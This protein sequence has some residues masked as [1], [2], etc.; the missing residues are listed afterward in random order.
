MRK[1]RVGAETTTSCFSARALTFPA[2][3]TCPASE[4]LK[5]DAGHDRPASEYFRFRIGHPIDCRARFWEPPSSNAVNHF[6]LCTVQRS[7]NLV[8]PYFGGYE[9]LSLSP[10]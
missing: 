6:K 2:P 1:S 9:R 3:A 4:R 8:V 5:I 10:D 7:P